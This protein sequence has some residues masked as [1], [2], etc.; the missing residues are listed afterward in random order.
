M[1]VD[2]CT[3]EYSL[4]MSFLFSALEISYLKNNRKIFYQEDS[5]EDGYQQLFMNDDCE[6]RYDTTDGQAA[7]IP[8]EYLGGKGIVPKETNQR[9]DK[10]ADK[11]Y[12]FFTAG[13][14][15]DIKVSRIF[16][17][18]GHVCQYAQGKADDG[19]VPGCHSVHSVI[20]VGIIAGGRCG[21][22]R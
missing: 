13:N 4:Q 19:G 5:A 12:Q 15:H 7:G 16:D 1:V 22:R 10:G 8:H 3:F 21:I 11:D 18:A 9:A 14:I 6:Y 2:R 20:Q 17:V